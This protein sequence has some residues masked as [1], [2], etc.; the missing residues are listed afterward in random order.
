MSYWTLRVGLVLTGLG[1]LLLSPIADYLPVDLWS[2][3]SPASRGSS[4][5][6]EYFRMV[7]GEQS[8]LLEGALVGVGL[9]LVAITPC[10]RPAK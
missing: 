2:K 3:L 6:L 7:R 10:L 1:L 8:F 5:Q 4:P 9:L